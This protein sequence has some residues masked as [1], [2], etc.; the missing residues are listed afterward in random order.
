MNKR[1]LMKGL[2]GGVVA[3]PEIARQATDSPFPP[4]PVLSA[5]GPIDL[6]NPEFLAK[7]AMREH[8]SKIAAREERALMLREQSLERLKS[9]SDAYKLYMREKFRKERQLVSNRM[10]ELLDHV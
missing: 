6:L 8:I 5:N 3:A 1:D 7:Q 9:V 4:P 2:I 10:F